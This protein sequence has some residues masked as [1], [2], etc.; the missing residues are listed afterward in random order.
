MKPNHDERCA[1]CFALFVGAFSMHGSS[2]AEFCAKK[3]RDDF[4]Q[5]EWF[6]ALRV[7]EDPAANTEFFPPRGLDQQRIHG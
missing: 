1:A 7:Q 2:W 5:E 3:E 4:L 6:E